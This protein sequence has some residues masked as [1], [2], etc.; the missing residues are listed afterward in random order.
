MDA[1]RLTGVNASS[2]KY[3]LLTAL[4]VTACHGDSRQQSSL[5]RLNL[6]I[7]A[8]YNWRLDEFSV[9]Q[10]DLARMWN[11]TERTV[12]REIKY[13]LEN[14]Y[15]ICKR[16]GARGRVGAYRLNYPEIYRQSEPH[17][18]AVGPDFHERM[19]ETHPVQQSKV[20]AVDFRAATH[21][22]KQATVPAE[23]NAPKTWRAAC[24]RIRELQ[25]SHYHNWISALSFVSDDGRTISL[26]THNKFAAHY[27]RTQLIHVIMEAIEAT[28][29]P[30]QHITIDVVH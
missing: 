22:S 9:G 30:R 13:W 7:T 3:D 11:V 20:V 26:Q 19:A 8:R 16:R 25:P 29:G 27:V 6:L 2:L 21:A 17:W 5:T 1:K 15:L 18:A 14:Q 4:S 12:K 24:Q 28:I 10:R 23:Q